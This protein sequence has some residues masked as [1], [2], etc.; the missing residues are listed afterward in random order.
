MKKILCF[1]V[2]EERM[3]FITSW[4]KE[5]N[6]TV[7][8]LPD[9]LTMDNVDKVEGYDAITVAHVG[10]FDSNLYA[11]LQKRGIKQ[12][13]QRTAGYEI[14]DLEK[15][16]EHGIIISNVPTYSPESIAEYTLL[17]ALQLVRKQ[18]LLDQKVAERDFRWLPDIRARVVQD[19]TVGIV[20]V[21]HI[22]FLVAK[23]FKGFGANVI[24]YDPYPKEGIE[25]VLTYC[26]SVEELVKQSD[27]VSLHMPA[28][29][30]NYHLFNKEMFE[31]MKDDAYLVNCGRGTLVNTEDLI[32]A[33]NT[34]KIAGA[35][36]DVYENESPYV[37]GKFDSDDEIEDKVFLELLN[38]PN[39][40]FYHHCAYYTDVSIKN[41]TQFALDAALE[42]AETNDTKYRVN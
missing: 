9:Y 29:D 20:G 16:T 6:V 15:A 41:M 39:I 23:L 12:I 25:D 5:H 10:A 27:I 42:V 22:G 40:I 13:A 18:Q 17:L 37:P 1:N 36:L 26:D 4:A 30:S 35:A 21:G 31:I 32:E 8:C 3:P 14:F 33:V 28:F 24:G 38:N 2:N 7:D 19:M 11:E 34:G